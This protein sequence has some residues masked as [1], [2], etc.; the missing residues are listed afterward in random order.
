M[1]H[2]KP[3]TVE[4]NNLSIPKVGCACCVPKAPK[5]G[6]AGLLNELLNI[7]PG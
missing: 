5:D 7:E 3:E 2:L 4:N 1:T 6:A